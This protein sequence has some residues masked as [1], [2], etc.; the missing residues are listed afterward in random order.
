M[1]DRE[2]ADGERRETVGELLALLIIV[3]HMGRRLAGETHGES[4]D[5]VRELNDTLHQA[6]TT[7]E[8]IHTQA[9]A[10]DEM[11]QES[12]P[13]QYPSFESSQIK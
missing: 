12:Q 2:A 11:P 1:Q 8:H 13:W 7:I 4:Y 3:Q 9:K 10:R 5:L 6:R